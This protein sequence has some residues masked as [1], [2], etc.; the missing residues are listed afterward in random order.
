MGIP[1]S[2]DEIVTRI[3]H[4]KANDWDWMGT[5]IDDL[6]GYL[7]FAYA[8]PF[9]ND[10]VTEEQWAADVVDVSAEKRP[11]DEARAYLSFA[12]DKCL[13]HRGISASRS[14]NHFRTWFWLAGD[15]KTLA[16]I[17]DD[18]NY[19]QYGAP[20]LAKIAEVLG[21]ALPDD[22]GF[23]RMAKGLRCNAGHDCGCG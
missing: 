17:E 3:Q 9:L 4:V 13:D 16:F 1:R 21:V 23:T 12:F 6:V 8:K 22:E 11:L 19:P 15:D 5:Q 7:D 14:L 18:A 10:D 2:Q 20:V